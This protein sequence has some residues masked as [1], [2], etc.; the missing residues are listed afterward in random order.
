M[1][2]FALKVVE[3]LPVVALAAFGGITRTVAGKMRGE[4][5]SIR[6]AIPEIII[7]IF[8]GIV[9][10]YVCLEWGITE[11]LRTAAV[12]LAGYS[13]RAVLALLDAFFINWV[14]RTFTNGDGNEKK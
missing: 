11:N 14:K 7:A 13:S 5:Y 2:T 1:K 3:L 8:S 10:H 12:A 9:I 6:I 4:P